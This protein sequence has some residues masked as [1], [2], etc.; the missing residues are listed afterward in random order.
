[1]WQGE[2]DAMFIFCG[3]F[4][5]SLHWSLLR[6]SIKWFHTFDHLKSFP[7]LLFSKILSTAVYCILRIISPHPILWFSPFV[8]SNWVR[9]IVQCNCFIIHFF[10][11]C[12]LTTGIII[13]LLNFL[14]FATLSN[15]CLLII[16]SRSC[17]AIH[18]VIYRANEY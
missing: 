7:V 6:L 1:M 11:L 9:I 16:L 5:I 12:H 8:L 15:I 18:I 17:F 2:V 14:F 10:L 13:A 3:N 4:W